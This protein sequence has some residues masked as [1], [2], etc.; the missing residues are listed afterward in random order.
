[1]TNKA[2]D[3][4]GG[5]RRALQRWLTGSEHASHTADEPRAGQPLEAPLRVGPYAIL[6]KLGEGGMGA[7]YAAR[8]PRLERTVALKTIFRGDDETAR[9][10]FWREA[11]AAASFNHPNICQIF[12]I[13]EDAG[14]LF[15]AME[16]LEGESL[17]DKL[18]GGP[19]R[20][21][22]AL[23]IARGML[24]GLSAVHTRGFVHRDLK[25]SN[26]F[27]T[28]HGVKLLDFGLVRHEMEPAAAPAANLT[29]TGIVI[30]TP[31]YMAPEQALGEPV[32]ARC[33]LFATGAILFEMLTGRPAFGGK[34]IIDVLHAT[35]H[36]QPPALTGS[37]SIAAVDRVIR[38]AL[39][40][41]PHDRFTS[42]EEFVDELRALSHSD[43]E[44]TRALARPLTRVVVLPF[45]VLR[46]DPET[47]FLAFSLP[48]AIS[49]SL[50]GVGS[51][52]VRSSATAARFAGD[53]PDLK[54]LA[55]D[56]DVDRVVMGT[57]LR[58]GDEV[59]VTGQLVE[60]PGG[61]LLSSYSVHAPLGDLF[62]LQDNL[63]QR[64]VTALAPPLSSERPV[65]REKT[66]PNPRAYEFYL[67]ANEMARA[68]SLLPKARDL[69]LQ[70]LE[71]DPEFAN[72]WAQLGRCH[73]VIG[74]FVESSPESE[75]HAE[76]ALRRALAIDPDLSVAHKFY[77]AL[78]A[79]MGCADAA[80]VR[81]LREATRRGNDPELFAGLVHSLRYCGLY[82]ESM[83]AHA[84]ARRLDPHVTTSLE[85][86]LLMAGET[87]QLMATE[88]APGGGDTGIRIMGLGFAGRREEAI[89][90]IIAARDLFR[91]PA[92]QVWGA[93]LRAWL[94]R[95][96]PDM[97]MQRTRLHS[98][99]V[100]DDPEAIFL[101][102][103]IACDVGAHDD[104][105][106]FLQRAVARG[107]SAAPAL[108]RNPQFDP[109]RSAPAFQALLA[110]AE[111]G[112]RRAQVA[113][114]EVGGE[115]LLG[116]TRS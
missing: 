70:A 98:F 10:R 92:F 95:R 56:A 64:V 28:P 34:T 86:T 11:R 106:K 85:G 74:K 25:P 20:I 114:R 42:A 96:L 111:A 66:P 84:E 9:Q 43:S 72:A 8:D 45:R 19:M 65:A 52:I 63:T 1:V 105:L 12:E 7:V 93:F 50:S 90:E 32:D 88:S 15:I 38:R 18:R 109:L 29:R 113:F 94:E 23:P 21:A 60:T 27:L 110:D 112:R 31:R 49:T 104:G 102:G 54:M 51:L 36:E 91:L 40:K 24:T 78:E 22:D 2:G 47:D 48:D 16:L 13:G 41:S 76:T 73:R 103:W 58:V 35:I 17:A 97:E 6:R 81:L 62:A 33:D 37:P 26:V 69:Y 100:R 67:R 61:T 71:L 115:R 75:M 116:H 79:D 59:R 68:Y 3:P 44:G 77:A 101:Q 57:L 89:A 82:D 107:Y 55:A 4:P 83:A 53:S 5:W 30:G 80:A 99:K 39:A 46:P 108:T 87:E 14:A